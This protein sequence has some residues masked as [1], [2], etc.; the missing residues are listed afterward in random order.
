M[1]Q[2]GVVID[3]QGLVAAGTGACPS[4]SAVDVGV[5]ESDLSDSRVPGGGESETAWSYYKVWTRSRN[6]I[7]A[8]SAHTRRDRHRRRR[9]RVACCCVERR[10]RVDEDM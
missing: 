9:C 3:E 1:L 10:G 4:E 2:V 7:D 5:V 8:Q 6:S